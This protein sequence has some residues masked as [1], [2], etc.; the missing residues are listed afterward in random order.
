M[1]RDTYTVKPFPSVRRF[2]V[3]GMDFGGR[4]HCIHGLIEIDVTRPR[5]RLRPRRIATPGQLHIEIVVE[6]RQR[7]QIIPA[8]RP[9]ANLV[10][11][12]HVNL[13]LRAKKARL[14]NLVML[15]E[16]KHPNL[17]TKTKT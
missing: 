6:S 12:Q 13:I 10:I 5:Q 17:V 2:F 8:D 14:L 11:L 15:N 7:W 1:S 3:D 9:Q 4:K 16:V